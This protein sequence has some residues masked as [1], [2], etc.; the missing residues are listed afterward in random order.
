[1]IK[2]FENSFWI[3]RKKLSFNALPGFVPIN[4]LSIVRL[5]MRGS[6]VCEKAHMQIATSAAR[7]P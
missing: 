1:M 3:Q 7:T 4:E 5:G 6:K 2:L